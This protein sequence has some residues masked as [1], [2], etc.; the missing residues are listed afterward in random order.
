MEQLLQSE[1]S[2]RR[3]RREALPYHSPE[4]LNRVVEAAKDARLVLLGEASHGTSE[5]YTTRAEITKRL[6]TSKTI[7]FVAV[8]GDWPSCYE[9]NKYVKDL[10][11]NEA[12]SAAEAL[13]AFYRWPSWMWANRE[14]EA[15]IEWLRSY[16]LERPA[17]ERIGFYGLDVYSL[18]ESMQHIVDYLKQTESPLLDTALQAFGCFEPY[19]DDSQSYGISAGLIGEG[20]EEEIVALLHE[21][22]STRL[23][24]P[25]SEAELNAMMNTMAAADAEHYYRTMVRGG[26]D[27]WN[28]RD[29][30][31]VR[32]LRQLLDYH[33]PDAQ[34][35]LWE[36][37]T[38]IGDARATDMAADGMVNVGQLVRE[39]YRPA[40][41][42]SVGFGTH[43]GHVLAG[44]AWGAP[45]EVMEVPPAIQGSWEDLLAR[46]G[47]GENMLLLFDADAQPELRE[48]FGHRAIGVVYDPGYELGNYVPSRVPM[49]YDAFV[50]IHETHALEPLALPL[51]V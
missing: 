42:F 7:R 18:W 15:F 44:S 29:R 38:H 37:N 25:Q 33:G 50:F 4:D 23:G 1:S 11:D 34:A 8:E 26:P 20:C 30:H 39:Y 48:V 46:A 17:R 21:M 32:A 36:H 40:Q 12:K 22:Q 16:N 9:V 24:H 47:G 31:M 43:H 3:I 45:V 13:R 6:I 49:R 2:A 27:S 5:F 19:G 41:T 10:E 35:V 14:M 51:M 28:V